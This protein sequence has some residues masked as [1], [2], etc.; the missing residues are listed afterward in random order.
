MHNSKALLLDLL[1]IDSVNCICEA[2]EEKYKDACFEERVKMTLSTRYW[3]VKDL[4]QLNYG[5]HPFII[6]DKSY[7]PET[8]FQ[9]DLAKPE[10]YDSSYSFL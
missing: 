2:D 1:E 4:R 8:G 9:Q 6:P 7:N 5:S 10:F 3:V